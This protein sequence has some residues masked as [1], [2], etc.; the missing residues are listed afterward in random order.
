MGELKQ[1]NTG[2]V[3]REEITLGYKCNIRCKFCFYGCSPKD[4]MRGVDE[5][6][7]DI[8]LC[9]RYKIEHIELSG[10]EP[11]LHQDI[12]KIVE[13]CREQ[14]FKTICMITNGTLLKD[15]ETMKPLLDKGLNQFVF[16]LHGADAEVHDYLTGAKTFQDILKAIENARMLKIPFRINVVVNKRNYAELEKIASL[17]VGL[18]PMMINYL[19]YSPLEFARNFAQD[20]SARYSLIAPQICKAVDMVKDHMKVRIRYIP[21]C[22]VEGYEQYVCNVHQLHYD[23]Y[24]W[25]YILREQIHNG[26]FSKW[27]KIFIGLFHVPINRILTQDI[28]K[29]FHE[30]IIKTMCLVNSYKPLKCRGCKYYS[31]CDGLWRDYVDMY[32]AKELKPLKG[33]SV[34]DPAYLMRG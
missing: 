23:P 27:A 5:I 12:E 9:K 14:G 25:D 22:L 32:G 33:A 21:F 16:S 29:T 15:I 20:M 8:L 2:I 28:N 17:A 31:I 34:T 19:I 30:A 13:F 7:E 10:G 3:R 1:R 26:L 4:T 11:M 6:K 24:E 18:E